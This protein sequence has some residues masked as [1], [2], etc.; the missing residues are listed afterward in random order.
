MRTII[1][2]RATVFALAL[3]IPA[4]WAAPSQAA[5]DSFQVQ[6]TGGQQVPAVQ[7]NGMGTADMTY[8]P[9]TRCL[10]CSV[11]YSGLSGPVTMAH[12]HV[13]G[14]GTNGPVAISLTKAGS[15]VTNPIK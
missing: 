6:L 2:G 1:S 9:T 14:S 7:T 5:S 4:L 13:G 15:T 12:I 10:T 8:N 3:L 11:S